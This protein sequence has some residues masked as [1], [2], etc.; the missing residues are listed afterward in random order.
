MRKLVAQDGFTFANENKNKET[1]QKSQ[2]TF[3]VESLIAKYRNYV[4]AHSPKALDNCSWQDDEG[5]W[6]LDEFESPIT[7]DGNADEQLLVAL[8]K[9][10]AGENA[11]S[12]IIDALIEYADKF[13]KVA[14]SDDEYAFLC[15]NFSN[16]VSYEFSH[17]HDWWLGSS[18]RISEKRIQ[19]VQE[20]V[21]SQKGEKIF[22]ADTEY[23]DLAVLFPECVIYGFTGW[24]YKQ[25]E[26]WALGQIR[27]FAAGI[28]SEIV[29]GEE[30]NENNDQYSYTLPAKGTMDV[31]IFRVNENNYFAQTIFGTECKN[32]EALYDL[33]KPDGKMLFFSEFED[34]MAGKEPSVFLPEAILSFR[35]RVVAEK[36]ISCIIEYEDEAVLKGGKDKY[37][38]IIIEKKQNKEVLFKD[39]TTSR[40]FTTTAESIC[41]DILWP[42]FYYTKRPDSG[43]P[44]SKLVSFMD[45]NERLVVKD[46]DN[47][48]LSDEAKQ[49]PYVIPMAKEYKD[50]NIL[51]QKSDLV[52]S[53]DSDQD[54][55]HRI[56]SIKER[57][58]LLYGYD[59][60]FFVGYIN[61]IPKTG[62]ATLRSIVCII[63]K[64]GI[65]VRYIAALLL[66]PVVKDQIVSI[67]QGDIDAHTFHIIM[68]YVIV[69]NH[70]D[71]EMLAFLS[72]AN[73]K[74]LQSVQKEMQSEH[75]NYIKAIRMRKHALTQSLSS[76]EAMFYALN[77]FRIRQNGNLVNDAVISRVKGTTVREAFEFISR[78]LEDM[79]PALEHIAA[80][81][82]TFDKPE[83]ID[84]ELFIE[85]YIKR[86][87]NGWLNFK[88]VTMWKQGHNQAS[89]N[90]KDP[91]SGDI[92]VL[93]GTSIHQFL[94]PKD[95]LEHVFKNIVSNA[96]SHGFDNN[97][98]DD[99]KLRFSW[100][101]E[102]LALVVEID[103][104]GSPISNDI[105]TASLLEYG[106]STVLHHDGHNGIGCNEIDDIM[107]RYDGKVQI[108]SSPVD[109]FP[110]K[111]ILT[112]NRSNIVRTL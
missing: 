21:K 71:K 9:A 86:N 54:L 93:K 74:A 57:C 102:G 55:K 82:Y 112:F 52:G 14:F 53:N 73:Y 88:S 106:V 100:H 5:K 44:L 68:D 4:N 11:D 61:E 56:K 66:T 95:A 90:I 13:Q 17:R 76:I 16:V 64:E 6:H 65:D 70:S 15:D 94:F 7:P 103:N 39:E 97:T 24:N 29:S 104:N 63:P 98:R 60:E 101:M 8:Y 31:V 72:E 45:N 32:I 25:K 27:L 18:R 48:V 42:S 89:E 79:M 108:V 38:L 83:W 58:I 49:M 46:G 26:V 110:V 22:I 1:M 81:D 85:E 12:R 28:R 51:T 80:I 62:I 37:F 30:V 19:F 69:P 34:E 92:I 36:S 105:D 111:Y 96:Q 40:T 59:K 10:V 43:I 87:E 77:E 33:L 3:T 109:E 50:A 2:N 99:Y 84:P 78:N 67:C 23:C 47:W 35:N 91:L 107:Q 20:Y 41:K 75:K